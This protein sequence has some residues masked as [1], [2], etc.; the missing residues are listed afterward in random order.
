LIAS[1]IFMRLSPPIFEFLRCSDIPQG[2]CCGFGLRPRYLIESGISSAAKRLRSAPP[3]RIAHSLSELWSE[4]KPLRMELIHGPVMYRSHKQNP[5][6]KK[7]MSRTWVGAIFFLFLT[8]L[9]SKA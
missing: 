4:P 7:N 8:R 5:D 1:T 3:L 2:S 6:H 9:M